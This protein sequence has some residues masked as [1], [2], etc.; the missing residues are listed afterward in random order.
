[1]IEVTPETF[2]QVVL[3]SSTPVLVDFYAAW[4]GPCKAAAPT[5]EALSKEF[6]SRAVVA[7]YDVDKGGDLA[8]KHGVRGIPAFIL[9]VDGTAIDTF[10]GWNSGVETI[11][12]EALSA[13][14]ASK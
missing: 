13:A 14:L 5:I 3:R 9:F 1:M 7:K 11:L 8:M 12:R 6:E 4:C 2:E 10:V